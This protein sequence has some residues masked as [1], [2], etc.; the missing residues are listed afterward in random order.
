MTKTIPVTFSVLCDAYGDLLSLRNPPIHEEFISAI[1]PESIG[2]EI[3]TNDSRRNLFFHAVTDNTKNADSLFL[4][5]GAVLAKRDSFNQ[6]LYR[7]ENSPWRKT[8]RENWEKLLHSVED[9]PLYAAVADLVSRWD[10]G[11]QHEVRE[12]LEELLA[13]KSRNK[14]LEALTC[15]T[16]ISATGLYWLPERW[17]RSRNK[18]CYKESPIIREL[19][20]PPPKEGKSRTGEQ[21]E[22]LRAANDRKAELTLK[23]IREGSLTGPKEV[24]R[25][26]LSIL[27]AFP[28]VSPEFRGEAAYYL[29]QHTNAGRFTPPQGETPRHYLELSH[30]CGYRKAA[31][32]WRELQKFA[33]RYDPAPAESHSAGMC[34][35]NSDN[36]RT[37]LLLKTVPRGWDVLSFADSCDYVPGGQQK[38]L[39]FRDDYRQNLKDTLAVLQQIKDR[40]QIEGECRAEIYLRGKTEVCAP[41]VDTALSHMDGIVVPVYIL[42]DEKDAA[43][44]LLSH[45]PLFYPVRKLSGNTIEK[46]K[47]FM[48]EAEKIHLNFLVIGDTECASWLVREAFWMLTFPEDSRIRPRIFLCGPRAQQMMDRL[49]GSFPGM[50]PAD[51][52]IFQCIQAEYGSGE[53]YNTLA[54][55]ITGEAEYSYF[56]LDTGSDEEN[57]TCAIRLR[58]RLIRS[59]VQSPAFLKSH[60][61][62]EL[63]VIAFRCQDPDLALLSRSMVVEMEAYGNQWFNNQ[64]LIPF[65]SLEHRYHWD[66]VDGGLI[67]KLAR[68]IHQQYCGV[69]EAGKPEKQEAMVSYYLHQYNR[70][71]SRAVAAG[72]ACRLFQWHRYVPLLPTGWSILEEEGILNANQL[73]AVAGKLEEFTE[74][75][76]K[77]AKTAK[78]ALT[79]WEKERWNRFMLSRGWL[80]ASDQESVSYI[81][82]GNPRQQLFIARTHPCIRPFEELEHLE[83]ILK[84]ETGMVNNFRASDE[85]SIADTHLLIRSLGPEREQEPER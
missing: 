65:G 28:Q 34:Y 53:F 48:P 20:L 52:A 31:E 60:Q 1:L 32:K 75:H 71:S 70:D 61:M 47:F 18:G 12:R 41:L 68:R 21:I 29:Y 37:R 33:L 72:T 56:A 55:R 49:Q 43:Q 3:I 16:L 46:L 54:Q 27:N 79:L 35:V 39:F 50:F 73:D 45:H 67:E 59:Q 9:Q 69:L 6:P 14:T 62:P 77:E 74:N 84:E 2:S 11:T 19:I 5:I 63:P 13:E 51:G 38:Y 17:D 26:C 57:L 25:E 78:R 85:N 40:R 66:R 80:T 30:N 10:K 4:Q 22:Q 8:V 36:E 82:A 58:E 44:Q 15:L 81:R 24:C 76:P 64:G 42:D 7:Y 23:T 83:Q